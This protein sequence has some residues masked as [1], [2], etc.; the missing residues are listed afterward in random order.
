MTAATR[1]IL[2]FPSIHDVIATETRLKEAGVWCDMVPVPRELS[3]ECGMA[4]EL[5]EADLTRVEGL[6]T[7]KETRWVSVHYVTQNPEPH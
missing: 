5:R 3:S 1:V 2:L 6:C 4:V 7:G